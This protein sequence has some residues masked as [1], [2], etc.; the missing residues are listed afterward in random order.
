MN[1]QNKLR[2]KTL[3]CQYTSFYPKLNHRHWFYGKTPLCPLAAMILSNLILICIV[4]HPWRRNS[5]HSLCLVQHLAA[6]QVWAVE[7]FSSASSSS[8]N[9]RYIHLYMSSPRHRFLRQEGEGNHFVITGN[10][11]TNHLLN[12]LART[13]V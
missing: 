11:S 3:I 7:K 2:E 4:S 8:E 1:V 9:E 12:S 5:S 10:E 6:F 13:L